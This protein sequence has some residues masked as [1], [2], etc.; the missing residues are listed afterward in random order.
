MSTQG[1]GLNLSFDV[2]A[3]LPRDIPS[4]EGT[5]AERR[6]AVSAQSF[7]RV[8][9]VIEVGSDFLTSTFAVFAAYYTYLR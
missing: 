5:S 4:L 8:M 1:D 9:T 2:T 7:R 3:K 6:F